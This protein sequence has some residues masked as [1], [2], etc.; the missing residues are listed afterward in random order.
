MRE[1]EIEIFKVN[2]NYEEFIERLGGERSDNNNKYLPYIETEAVDEV[3]KD[4][5][6]TYTIM[7]NYTK[8]DR[9]IPLSLIHIFN[10]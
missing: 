3:I 4:D 6:M 9:T 1:R 10:K 7:T 5:N 8:G 2:R